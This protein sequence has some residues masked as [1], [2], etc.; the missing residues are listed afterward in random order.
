MK[1]VITVVN[2]DDEEQVRASLIKKGYGTTSL[3]SQGNFLHQENRLGVGFRPRGGDG[4]QAEREGEEQQD[5]A[6]F[7]HGKD[8]LTDVDLDI[9]TYVFLWGNMRRVRCVLLAEKYRK[10]VDDPDRI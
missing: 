6:E 8:L 5:G 1:L 9:R 3:S 4:Q 10:I 2:V 7:L